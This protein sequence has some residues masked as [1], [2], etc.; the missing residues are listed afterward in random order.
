MICNLCMYI[1]ADI[2]ECFNSPNICGDRAS[3]VD[4]IGSFQCVCNDGYSDN[5]TGC[6]GK[7]AN[8][9]TLVCQLVR[10]Y[11]IL[12]ILMNVNLVCALLMLS[13]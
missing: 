13:V 7:I 4:T 8:R 1:S 5:G 9:M 12:Q 6:E 2:D 3:C 10:M 11:A